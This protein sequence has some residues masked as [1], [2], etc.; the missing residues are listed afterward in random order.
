MIN[1]FYFDFFKK[2]IF[3]TK[4]AFLRVSVHSVSTFGNVLIH[5]PKQLFNHSANL[6]SREARPVFTEFHDSLR[7]TNRYAML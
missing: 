3:L 7:L 4:R 1:F 2:D 5:R 6:E